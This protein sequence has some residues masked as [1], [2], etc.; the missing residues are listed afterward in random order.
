MN[1]KDTS[2]EP[3]LAQHREDTVDLKRTGVSCCCCCCC[4]NKYIRVLYIRV[5]QTEVRG[6]F[7]TARGMSNQAR[8][9]TSEH[10]RGESRTIIIESIDV[11]TWQPSLDG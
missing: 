1:E 4:C 9:I 6:P 2:M 11:L 3:E 10:E 7:G 8:H 5:S